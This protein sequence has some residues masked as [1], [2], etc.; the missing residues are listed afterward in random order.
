M[1]LPLTHSANKQNHLS[2]KM[3]AYIRR[4]SFSHSTGN[5]TLLRIND[6][7]TFELPLQKCW[8]KLCQTTCWSLDTTTHRHDNLIIVRP[9]LMLIVFTNLCVKIDNVFKIWHL[10]VWLSVYLCVTTFIFCSDNFYNIW[11]IFDSKFKIR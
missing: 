4:P 2:Q 7:R 9:T 8:R 5:F 11:V 1:C 6:K 10:F 3:C